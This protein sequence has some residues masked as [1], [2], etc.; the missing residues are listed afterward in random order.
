MRPRCWSWPMNISC[1]SNRTAHTTALRWS[2]RPCPTP[3]GGPGTGFP[4][5]IAAA[6]PRWTGR[7][8]KM[9]ELAQAGGIQPVAVTVPS[10][11]LGMEVGEDPSTPWGAGSEGTDGQRWVAEHIERRQMLNRLISDY[12]TSRGVAW[13]DL[14]A[15]T[16]EPR[17]MRLAAVYSNDGLHLSTE[18]YSRLAELL[19]QQVFAGALTRAG[20]SK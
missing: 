8:L 3:G 15:A 4:V 5:S 19:Y 14:F 16:L 18:G 9:Y 2:S 11:R 10:I 17:T 1:T 20:G 6:L 13:I 12:C 7:L